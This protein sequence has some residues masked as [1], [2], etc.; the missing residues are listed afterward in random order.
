MSHPKKN[1]ALAE[2]YRNEGNAYFRRQNYFDA[3]MQY[4]QSLC[5]AE[6]GTASVG[7]AFANRSAVYVKLNQFFLC[8]ENIQLARKHKYPDDNLEKLDQ[9]EKECREIMKT[10]KP[11]P[12]DDPFKFF[13]LSYPANKKYPGIVDCIELRN[14]QKFGN[15]LITTQNLK[16]GDIIAIEEP[17]FVTS[18]AGARLHRCSYCYKDNLFHMLPCPKCTKGE[19]KK[20][21]LGTERF[22][23]VHLILVCRKLIRERPHIT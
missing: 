21:A 18:A 4:N 16:P 3:L 23:K 5:F 2:N 8:L 22:Y 12:D 6:T 10:L 15:H 13:K 14:N 11:N 1:N 7:L 9:R 20:K 19:N 17:T